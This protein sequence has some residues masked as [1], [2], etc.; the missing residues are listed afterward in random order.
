[1][2]ALAWLAAAGCLLLVRLP[3]AALPRADALAGRGRLAARVRAD[4]PRLDRLGSGAVVPVAVGCGVGSVAVAV[5]R[6]G[7]VMG[8]AA[9]V[10]LATVGAMIRTAHR[11]RRATRRE[12]DLRTAIGLVVAE[13]E[14]GSTPAAALV[15]AAEANGTDRQC[16]A[17]AAEQA[18]VGG[19]LAPAFA[20]AG[21]VLKPIGHA[22]RIAE[23]T[24]A[25]PADVLTRI[26]ADLAAVQD[27][28]RA[29]ASALAGPRSSALML[30][31]LPLLGIVLGVT[32][33]ADPLAFLVGTP[34]GRLVCCVG[35]LFDACGVWWTQ[36][37]LANA[38][39]P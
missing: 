1:M 13:L 17:R 2:S 27:Q 22:W 25:R 35:V 21:G 32:M 4:A 28:R 19:S 5:V 33:G 20:E 16:F 14:A 36:R 8:I 18:R 10:V 38:V 31:A 34:T 11:G 6:G 37:L 39:P 15:A 29:V 23:S 7:L 30:A 24:G 12:R 9:S 26:G 3:S